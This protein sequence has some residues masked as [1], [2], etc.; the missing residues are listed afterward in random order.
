MCRVALLAKRDGKPK[1]LNDFTSDQLAEVVEACRP[2]LTLFTTAVCGDN[3][4]RLADVKKKANR[5]ITFSQIAVLELH[6]IVCEVLQ[7][8]SRRVS[9]DARL[10][11]AEGAIAGKDPAVI[12][13]SMSNMKEFGILRS[14]TKLIRVTNYFIANPGAELIFEV[15]QDA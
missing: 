1:K 14:F 13:E 6:I 2:F 9:F 12:S 4:K 8:V 10:I 7:N 15:E 3:L 5:N 11:L